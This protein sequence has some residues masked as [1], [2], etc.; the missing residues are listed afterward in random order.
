MTDEITPQ[1]PQ[2]QAKKDEKR[3]SN[4]ATQTGGGRKRNASR[5]ASVSAGNPGIPRPSSRTSNK[6]SK[7]GPSNPPTAAESGSDTTKKGTESKKTEQRGK[8][9]AGGTGRSAGHRKGQS[10]AQSRGGGN[11]P[12][13]GP[14]DS[15]APQAGD[16]SDALSSLQRVIADL[17]T[18]S[19]ANQSPNVVAGSI[20]SSIS[21][22][23]GQGSALPPNAP[24][25]QPGAGAYPGPNT[26][27]PPRHRKAASLGNSSNPLY[28]SYSPNLGSMMEDVEE[29]QVNFP[30]E[31]GEI[32]EN[33]YQ[34]G[35]PRRS[36]SQSFTAPRF[37]ALAAQQDQGEVLG[38]TGRPQLAPGFMFGARRRPSSTVN[39]PMGPPISEEDVGFQFPQ[40]QNQQN[41]DM[42]PSEM[43]QRKAGEGPE[44]SGI[45]AEQVCLTRSLECGQTAQFSSV[46]RPPES[47]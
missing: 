45:M 39:M 22:S 12:K 14:S 44:I 11:R 18:T 20:T 43:N 28:N 23:G 35:H 31:E 9:Q 29:G 1:P 10:T 30:T 32:Q 8:P 38:P 34:S 25:F 27:L 37:A 2:N 7:R 6:S 26:E 16:N 40:Q 47:D 46:D 33:M 5:T 19:P 36:L 21:M 41:F 15:P 24:V 13:E 17:K 42:P 3:P 4:G